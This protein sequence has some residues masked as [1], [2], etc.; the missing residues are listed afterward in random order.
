MKSF[1]KSL[2]CHCTAFLIDEFKISRLSWRNNTFVT[3][4]FLSFIILNFAS[5]LYIYTCRST[6]DLKVPY[7]QL[8]AELVKSEA[9][10][11]IIELRKFT[12]TNVFFRQVKR[13][14]L[15]SSI[16]NAEQLKTYHWV[17]QRTT[18]SIKWAA[19]LKQ[20]SQLNQK[21]RQNL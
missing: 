10:L 18:E 21:H 6:Q 19:L 20:L 7:S 11:R 17:L 1:L 12:D 15:N 4:I 5:L 14:V 16:K 9:K 8:D 13:K 3:V 2:F